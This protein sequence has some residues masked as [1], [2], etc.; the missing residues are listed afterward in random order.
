MSLLARQEL[1][2]ASKHFIDE[3]LDRVK[4]GDKSA[5]DELLPHIYEELRSLARRVRSRNPASHTINTTALV[6]EAYVRLADKGDGWEDRRHFFR[7]AARAMRH[8]L[9]DY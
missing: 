3:L 4:G 8:I 2:G 6:H 5:F 9:V 7:V 1:M